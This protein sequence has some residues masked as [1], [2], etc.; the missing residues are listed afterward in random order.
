ML[1]AKLEFLFEKLRKERRWSHSFIF[2]ITEILNISGNNLYLWEHR[3]EYLWRPF[4]T[5]HKHVCMHAENKC[6]SSFVCVDRGPKYH[7]L[8]H[9]TL[10]L[11]HIQDS[12]RTHDLTIS[13]N[14]EWQPSSICPLAIFLLSLPDQP[15]VCFLSS[16]SSQSRF[17]SLHSNHF[18]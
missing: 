18:P 12:F 5:L 1:T 9:T 2:H 13:G 15:S 11:S 14:G 3:Q 8:A 10:S 6:L 17:T 16:Y 4:F 7:L